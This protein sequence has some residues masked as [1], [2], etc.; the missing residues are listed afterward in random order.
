MDKGCVETLDWAGTIALS[1]G[2]SSLAYELLTMMISDFPSLISD[3]ECAA[4][5]ENLGDMLHSAHKMYGSTAYCAVPAL[6]AA[7]AE[8]EAILK[9]ERLEEVEEKFN[10]VKSRYHDLV[11]TMATFTPN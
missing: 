6:R 4:K 2:N 7:T 8:L 3:F 11:T 1:S 9:T 10:R 5:T